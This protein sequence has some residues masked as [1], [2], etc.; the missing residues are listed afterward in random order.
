MDRTR[1]CLQTDGQ[2]DATAIAI[3]PEPFGRGIK[4]NKNKTVDKPKSQAFL[5]TMTKNTGK[6]QTDRFKTV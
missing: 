1:F 5:H 2:T 4:S 3:S 6:F